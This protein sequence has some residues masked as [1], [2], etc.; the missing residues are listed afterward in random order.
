[1]SSSSSKV[2]RKTQVVNTQRNESKISTSGS[3]VNV[4]QPEKQVSSKIIKNGTIKN[5][6]NILKS[7]Q[8]EYEQFEVNMNES[9]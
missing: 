7:I 1:M 4:K 3:T 2:Q 5:C 6:H 9:D 8:R